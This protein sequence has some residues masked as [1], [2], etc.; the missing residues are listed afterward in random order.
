[1][2]TASVSQTR[3]AKGGMDNVHH[4]HAVALPLFIGLT[5]VII[6]DICELALIWSIASK[7][8][9]VDNR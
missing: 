9:E 6:Y 2:I 8:E 7:L 5:R 3:S 4:S 1:M